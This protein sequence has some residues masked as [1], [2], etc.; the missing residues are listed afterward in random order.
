M[1]MTRFTFPIRH[2]GQLTGL[3][4]PVLIGLD[5]TKTIQLVQSGN[6]VPRTVLGLGALD[7]ACDMTTVSAVFLQR[8][9][10]RALRTVQT[11]GVSGGLK[12][13]QYNV[14]LSIPPPAGQGA[15]SL[16]Y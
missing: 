7:T 11:F 3:L 9:Q 2:H 8:L 14:S 10:V 6:P 5:S 16:H 13:Q 4:V 1:A 12:A 15:T